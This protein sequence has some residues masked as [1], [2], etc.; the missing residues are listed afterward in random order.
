MFT[1]INWYEKGIDD[2]YEYNHE[3]SDEESFQ[4]INYL[5]KNYPELNIEWISM[6]EE[7]KTILFEEDRIDDILDFSNSYRKVFPNR[8]ETEYEFIERDLIGHLLFKGDI[9]TVKER[10]EIIKSNPVQ[11]IDTVTVRA[12]F[13][14]IYHGHY[15]L[16]LEYS[17]A[18]W[19]KLLYSNMTNSKAYM[20]FCDTVFLY[21][22]ENFYLDIKNGVPL[23]GAALYGR[24]AEYEFFEE[25][26][27]Y[28]DVFSNL[29]K[30]FDI[31]DIKLKIEHHDGKG[32]QEIDKN[33]GGDLLSTIQIQFLKY[34]KEEF[35]MPFLLS[36]Q[37]FSL[38][39]KIEL[40]GRV[41]PLEGYFYIPYPILSEHVNRIY[42]RM[43]LSNETEVFGKVFG[44]KYV[45][46]F[47]HTHQLINDHYYGMMEEN[48][49]MLENDFMLDIRESL[50][51]MKFVF[52]W[53]QLSSTDL[54]GK[55]IFSGTYHYYTDASMSDKLEAYLTNYI[56]PERI[57]NEID[58]F[59]VKKSEERSRY[60]D[61]LSSSKPVINNEPK[62]GRNDPCPCGSGKKYKKCCMK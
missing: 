58:E 35:E 49:R 13:E 24:M 19:P 32:N 51:Q 3:L 14:L 37:F 46:N 11:G 6:F 42:D 29:R 16:A 34:M 48:I 47:L 17:K 61:N 15:N 1:T 25:E 20:V 56:I 38:F 28:D 36:D 50:W 12:L 7:I 33:L 21:E 5:L 53:P 18:V 44:M 4:F 2:I 52:D 40:F 30:P 27:D 41:D 57:Q 43:F 62:V 22:L 54:L 23:N 9:E 45:Y 39:Q 10:L 55:E 60:Y 31:Q 26:Y 8:Y 59:E